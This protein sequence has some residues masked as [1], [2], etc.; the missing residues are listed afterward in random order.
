MS[1]KSLHNKPPYQIPF[2]AS[3]VPISSQQIYNIDSQYLINEMISMINTGNLTEIL[4]FFE[5]HHG[6]NLFLTDRDL[7]TPIHLIIRVKSNL[8]NEDVKIALIKQLISIPYNLPFDKSNK[9]I[10]TP[11]HLAIIL[12]YEKIVKQLLEWGADINKINANH[13]NALHLALIPIIHQCEKLITPEALIVPIQQT[14]DKNILYNQA[15]SIF[16]NNKT[17]FDKQINQIIKPN[18]KQIEKIYNDSVGRLLRSN[19]DSNGKILNLYQKQLPINRHLMDF[20]NSI[21]TL[22]SNSKISEVDILQ[23]ISE[24][25]KQTTKKISEDYEKLVIGGLA[26]INTE[27]SKSLINLNQFDILEITDKI[28]NTTD[29]VYKSIEDELK[30]QKDNVQNQIYDQIDQ[31]LKLCYLLHNIDR[32]N[33]TQIDV[34]ILVN[35]YL[36]VYPVPDGTEPPTLFSPQTENIYKLI[37]DSDLYSGRNLIDVYLNQ[38][39]KNN[40]IQYFNILIGPNGLKTLQINDE[41]DIK[42][43]NEINIIINDHISSLNLW[44]A[45]DNIKANTNLTQYI[46]AD[47]N[48]YNTQQVVKLD[49]FK[50]KTFSTISV[51]NPSNYDIVGIKINSQHKQEEEIKY[52]SMLVPLP[53]DLIP[54][55]IKK[56]FVPNSFTNSVYEIDYLKFL[57]KRFI[58]WFLNECTLSGSIKTIFNEI[59]NL[60]KNNLTILNDQTLTMETVCLIIKILDRLFIQTIRNEINLLAIEKVKSII[61]R[62][63]PELIDNLSSLNNQSDLFNILHISTHIQKL[64]KTINQLVYIQT[65]SVAINPIYD[66]SNIIDENSIKNIFNKKIPDFTSPDIIEKQNG[67]YLVHYQPDYQSLAPIKSRKCMINSTTIVNIILN[68]GQTMG[69]SIDYLKMDVNGFSPIYYA[70][71]ARNYLLIKTIF[72]KFGSI[73]SKSIQYQLNSYKKSPILYAY[74]LVLSTYEKTKRP[75]FEMINVAFIN[76]LLLTATIANNLP[77]NYY[78]NYKPIIHVLNEF[79]KFGF[80]SD[81]CKFFNLLNVKSFNHNNISNIS[82]MIAALS[83]QINIKL[84][85]NSNFISDSNLLPILTTLNNHILTYGKIDDELIQITNIKNNH[86]LISEIKHM[87]SLVEIFEKKHKSKKIYN[88]Y[89]N[90]VRPVVSTSANISDDTI[91]TINEYYLILVILGIIGTKDIIANH[92]ANIIIKEF[93]TINVFNFDFT[94]ITTNGPNQIGENISKLIKTFVDSNIFD[95]VRAYF[96]IKLDDFDFELKN[97]TTIDDFFVRLIDHL[98]TNGFFKLDSPSY[99]N[100][101]QY[102]HIHMIELTIQTLEY[103]QTLMDICHRWTINYYQSLRTF[104]EITK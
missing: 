74:D 36:Y 7:N 13:Q 86:N 48:I 6:N 104:D 10:E 90:N 81:K 54:T 100:I 95:M 26:D 57:K 97:K 1:Y 47:E 101:K 53:L 84:Q 93:Y 103:V 28:L 88:S 49:F 99:Y 9:F 69:K 63:T 89:I 82:T 77:T 67:D 4:N 12:Q 29:N 14:L 46:F 71:Y 24:Q 55:D 32:K 79:I 56:I 15:L 18:I 60:I 2:K 98:A 38:I 27:S 22:I 85:Y 51:P 17:L 42:V 41:F 40:L 94:N 78:D 20:Q 91:K 21:L 64:D 72:N 45:L 70:I 75:D 50:L 59:Y 39:N 35:N 43:S 92:Y 33:S 37:Y 102:V 73:V 66:K 83:N 96:E 61:Q 58:Y 65:N 25:I 34:P 3:Y 8:M 68:S 87:K 62:S 11:L 52:Q 76:N 80:D 44:L 23:T 30:F 19:N 16:Y 31:I 5:S